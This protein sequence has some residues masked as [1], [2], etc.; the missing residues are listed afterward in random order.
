MRVGVFA[1]VVALLVAASC[2]QSARVDVAKDVIGPEPIPETGTEGDVT[3]PD[4]HSPPAVD[5]SAPP[6]PA[7]TDERLRESGGMQ[8]GDHSGAPAQQ[9]YEALD[10]IARADAEQ[11][12]L[13]HEHNAGRQPLREAEGS[14]A[15][16]VNAGSG[17]SAASSGHNA[18]HEDQY[19]SNTGEPSPR[20]ATI[21]SG[22][23]ESANRIE[24]AA[25]Q[26]AANSRGGAEADG[27]AVA[28]GEVAAAAADDAANAALEPERHRGQEQG[29]H[30]AH[31]AAQA[32]RQADDATT[33]LAAGGPAVPA[34]RTFLCR[35][36]GSTV[37]HAADHLRDLR[38]PTDAQ[39][40]AA[41]GGLPAHPEPAAPAP[42]YVQAASRAE[43]ALGPRGALLEVEGHPA[44]RGTPGHVYE[45][46][47][48]RGSQ[49]SSG[50]SS[51]SSGDG[52]GSGNSE[53]DGG[54]L[55]GASGQHPPHKQPQ[56]RRRPQSTPR[57]PFFLAAAFDSGIGITL[58]AAESREGLAVHAPPP[59]LPGYSARSVHCGRC[60]AMLGHL[61]VQRTASSRR[62]AGDDA[63]ASA[64]AGVGVGG[65]A[66]GLQQA[67]AT[68]FSS[69]GGGSE[70][71]ATGE[72]AQ[73]QAS[74][75]AAQPTGPPPPPIAALAP[76][77]AA[78]GGGAGTT[79]ESTAG[80]ESGGAAGAAA[81]AA[82]VLS[83]AGVTV[84]PYVAGEEAAALR[85]LRGACLRFGSGG[86]WQ[87]EWCVG[88][89]VRQFHADPATGKA[90]PDWS[91]GTY[92]P[93]AQ[94]DRIVPPPQPT[95]LAPGGV[96]S[97]EAAAAAAA[98]AADGPRLYYS[99]QFY[100]GGQRCDENG[101]RRATEVQLYCC[102][103]HR[104]KGALRCWAVDPKPAVSLEPQKCG[105]CWIQGCCAQRRTSPLRFFALSPLRGCWHRK[106][107]SY[108]L[109]ALGWCLSGFCILFCSGLTARRSSALLNALGTCVWV[110][111]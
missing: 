64:A 85:H 82:A 101:K 107:L 24:A 60:G 28:A 63:S 49:A 92:D 5:G 72:A 102:P 83:A 68:S 61:V 105:C 65:A 84:R 71:A 104:D 108:P 33:D 21:A 31:D 59:P 87:Y 16:T 86:W 12:H 51:A 32:H 94:A 48:Q 38:L 27:T 93:S 52:S 90:D 69:S 97:P 37:F 55:P 45:A 106:R 50:T 9:S 95:A 18:P 74:E 47:R 70:G 62:T 40:A 67:G 7:A 35:V 79:H 91:L 39:L 111:A 30:D 56:G 53:T 54:S 44:F 99:S 46:D 2:E 76:G 96:G 3:E 13:E 58:G 41:A 77:E 43:A 103:R 26:Q 36:C 1:C 20:D 8:M 75:S 110:R 78:A 23:E 88:R 81:H 4:Q 15:T 34:S 57:P 17:D 100:R 25:E 42:R 14:G 66:A 6:V 29:E 109:L 89:H 10:E 73:P 80:S 22:S 98:A 19:G 11:H